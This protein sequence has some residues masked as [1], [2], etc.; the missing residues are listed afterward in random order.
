MAFK[1]LY[2]SKK[3]KDTPAQEFV[4][5]VAAIT[6]RKEITVRMWI[7]GAQRPDRLAAD[8]IAKWVGVDTAELFP[9]RNKVTADDEPGQGKE[10]GGGKRT[11]TSRT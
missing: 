9:E 2:E 7:S 8:T 11:R 6:K 5:T 3:R 1:E 4:K 10:K